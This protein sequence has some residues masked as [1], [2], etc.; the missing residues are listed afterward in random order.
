S[1]RWMRCQLFLGG[2]TV[3][4][5]RRPNAWN[6]FVRQRLNDINEGTCLSKGDCWKLMEFIDSHKETLR[7][8]YARLSHAQ[9]NAFEVEIM[10]MHASKQRMVHDNPKAVQRDMQATFA[11]MDQEHL[12]SLAL[13]R[14]Y[15]LANLIFL[16]IFYWP[17]AEDVSAISTQK[18]SLN[19]LISECRTHIQD[20]LGE[21]Y[22][23]RTL[24]CMKT[25]YN[26]YEHAIVE[27]HSVALDG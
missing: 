17:V 13:V 10:K 22:L 9:K 25:N 16:T 12:L 23:Y 11:A 5:R 7:V 4:H 6:A 24:S 26:N 15:T 8:D 20:E 19:K 21:H 14:F 1:E 27:H 3:R 2:Q 18:K